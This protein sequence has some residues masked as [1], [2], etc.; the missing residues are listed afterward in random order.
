LDTGKPVADKHGVEH[1]ADKLGN[2]LQQAKEHA[3]Q[4][5]Y[6]VGVHT[7]MLQHGKH[8]QISSDGCSI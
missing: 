6:P 1:L 5:F 4:E 3:I 7:L 2:I 8:M